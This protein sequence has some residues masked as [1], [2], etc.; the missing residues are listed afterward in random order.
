MKHGKVSARQVDAGQAVYTPKN[1]ANYDWF[2]LGLSNRFAWRCPT[3]E[4]LDH[5]NRHV[6]G[7]HLDVGVGTG[8][9]LDRCR[10]PAAKPRL[11]IMDLNRH[12]LEHTARRVNRYCPEIYRADVLEPIAPEI[13]AFDSIGINYLLRCLPG[14]MVT[15]QTAVRNLVPL[16]RPGGVMF[17]STI[18]G[19]SARRNALAR[20]LMQIYNRKG[21]FSNREDDLESLQSI[22]QRHFGTWS[23][24]SIG[25]VALFAAWQK[26]GREGGSSNPVG[27]V[28]C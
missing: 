16:L 2:V 9:F 8:Y 17:G 12:S 15:K 14:D 1:L 23:V 7:N 13:P 10:F 28:V 4:L 26:N 19:R 24:E 21:I 6:T 5:Y 20:A 3:T 18:L 27:N 22:L 25:C 11:A